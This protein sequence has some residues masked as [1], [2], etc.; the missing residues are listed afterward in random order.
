MR[1]IVNPS[2]DGGWKAYIR[3]TKQTKKE[4]EWRD[5]DEQSRTKGMVLTEQLFFGKDIVNQKWE[6]PV[7]RGHGAV[8]WVEGMEPDKCGHCDGRGGVGLIRGFPGESKGK[9][10][11]MR[12]QVFPWSLHK[13]GE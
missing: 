1:F 5:E 6:C 9:R 12:R 7:C 4:L 3:K 13:G 8:L 11:R 2:G 10:P